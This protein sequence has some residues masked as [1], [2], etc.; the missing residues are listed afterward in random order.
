MPEHAPLSPDGTIPRA[1][2]RA[3]PRTVPLVLLVAVLGIS[4]SGPL[5]R[6]SHAE[7]LAIAL[8]R[9]TLS[10][11]VIAVIL[12]AG[13]SW[14]Q[15]KGLNRGD[16]IAAG[17]AGVL[18][19]LHFWSWITSIG[20]TSVAAS[21]VLVNVHPVIV[22]AGSALFLG[23]RPS[24]VQAA[25]IAVSLAG[26][27]LLAWGDITAA[28]SAAHGGNALIG[29]VLAVIG[30]ITIAGYLLTG[31]R[32][33]QKLDLW[34]YV[35]LV[36]GACLFTVYVIAMARGTVIA[37]QP[38]REMLIFTGMA[39]GPMLIGHTGFNWALR[40][41]PAYVVSLVAIA[42][43][44]G[45]TALAAFLPGIGERPS[46]MTLVGGGVVLAGIVLA[47]RPRR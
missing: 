37:P 36:Y 18:L 31:R 28:P 19:A 10:M 20:F 43:P 29:D 14:R 16:L 44:I 4:G 9:L 2:P 27:G 47:S 6:L 39:L 1:V 46:V 8:W 3:V 23:E 26:A 32:V 24:R 11:S 33:R 5:V 17:V 21:V 15:W 22:A 45:A 42:E 7:P 40:Y 34:P 38:Q 12:L 30:A 41:V 25:G 13:G 35:G